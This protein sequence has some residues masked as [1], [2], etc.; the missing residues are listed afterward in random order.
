[1]KAVNL[2]TEH[3]T[4]PLGID[5]LRPYLT[6]NCREGIRQTAYEIEASDDGHILW[7]SG[8]VAGSE[9]NAVLGVNA[10]SRQRIVWKVRLWDENGI[11]G[12]WSEEAWFEMGL[13]EKKQFVAKWI[14]PELTCDPDEHKPA[15][16][17]RTAFHAP[18]GGRARLY[19]TC[20]G[21][22]LVPQ[23]VGS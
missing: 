15:S 3:L 6:W 9:M 19:I 14:N 17:L 23:R 8:K 11:P 10:V 2:K 21:G 16:Y 13:L 4:N 20:H 22:R 18:K 12:E 7:N 5:I 1:M